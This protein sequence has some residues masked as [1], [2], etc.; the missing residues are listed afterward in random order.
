MTCIHLER[1]QA[2]RRLSLPPCF[3]QFTAIG[4]SL[5]CLLPKNLSIGTVDT[6]LWW[7]KPQAG[8]SNGLVFICSFLQ[9]RKLRPSKRRQVASSSTRGG[10]GREWES[11]VGP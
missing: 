8:V 3:V 2:S 1:V 6:L 10:V 9:R 11:T 7:A 5:P 4:Q